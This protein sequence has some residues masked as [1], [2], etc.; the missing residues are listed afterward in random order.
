MGQAVSPRCELI[1]QEAY[2]VCFQVNV[3]QLT[4]TDF[5]DKIP[6]FRNVQEPLA[7]FQGV[8][9]RFHYTRKN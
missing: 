8:V 7:F 5:S 3:L 6:Q 4:L 2:L 9:T 1:D